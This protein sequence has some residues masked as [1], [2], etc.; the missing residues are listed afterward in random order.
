MSN[1]PKA[2]GKMRNEN[3]GKSALENDSLFS[4]PPTPI[5]DP[6]KSTGTGFD[7]SVSGQIN[8][9]PTNISVQNTGESGLNTA[10]TLAYYALTGVL[11]PSLIAALGFGIVKIIE[12]S[13]RITR[14]EES[15]SFVKQQQ[16]E[17]QAS[18]DEIRKMQSSQSSIEEFGKRID[19]LEAK[20][21]K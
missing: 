8:Q 1:P 12:F 14:S 3:E 13:E 15:L 10:K 2:K 20:T 11:V 21:F 4:F 5:G 9:P 19:R 6:A 7:G 16:V 17:L 18:F